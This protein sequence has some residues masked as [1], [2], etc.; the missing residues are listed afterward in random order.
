MTVFVHATS[1]GV[2]YGTHHH[3]RPVSVKETDRAWSFSCPEAGCEERIL[4]TVE[5]TSRSASTIPLTEHEKAEASLLEKRSKQET[6][7]TML[8][9]S[10]LIKGRIA[11][12]GSAA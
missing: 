9:L 6:S 1:G 10:D 5:H 3:D 8:A 11:E 12:S 4:R 2:S 7:E